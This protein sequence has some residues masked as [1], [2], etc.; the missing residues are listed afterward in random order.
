[1]KA[2]GDYSLRPETSTPLTNCNGDG[3]HILLVE[4]DLATAEGMANLLRC[5]GHRVQVAPD[6]HSACQAAL[7]K[8]PDVVL[9]DIAL[10]DL[11]GWEVA[12]RF[13]EP[14]WE[15]KPFLIALT[16]YGSEADRRRSQEAGIDLHLAKPIAPALLREI[17][18]RFHQVIMPTDTGPAEEMNGKYRDQAPRG[19]CHATTTKQAP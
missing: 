18:R 15:K 17:L 6:G 5:Y 16:G 11:D 13:Q 1:M 4:D 10:P 2:E 12:R 14:S 8:P 7:R 9:M 19:L 3:L